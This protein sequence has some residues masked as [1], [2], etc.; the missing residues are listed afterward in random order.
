MYIVF[1]GNCL[2]RAFSD[3]LYG[4]QSHSSEIRARVVEYMRDHPDDF[5]CFV[6]VEPHGGSRRNPKRK[7]TTAPA[8]DVSG[9]TSEQIDQAWEQHL[10]RMA[11]DREYGDNME[12]RAFGSAYSVD[13]RIYLLPRM[14]YLIS[15]DAALA[16]GESRQIV[17][18]ALNVSLHLAHPATYTSRC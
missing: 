13:I 4:D 14:A 12:V 7:N 1:E 10:V 16:A 11:R 2:F 9:P 6:N 3:Q 5:K 17:H 18:I 15:C 8:L